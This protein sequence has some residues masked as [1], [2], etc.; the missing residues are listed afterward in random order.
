[1]KSSVPAASPFSIRVVGVID[2]ETSE[3]FLFTTTGNA[4]PG[5]S[6][7]SPVIASHVGSSLPLKETIRSP[8]LKPACSAAPPGST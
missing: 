1:M 8:D 6:S 3:P 4:F 2:S 7:A 5:E